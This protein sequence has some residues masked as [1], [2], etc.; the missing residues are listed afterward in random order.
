[1]MSKCSILAFWFLFFSELYENVNI[2]LVMKINFSD[3]VLHSDS[4]ITGELTWIYIVL[5]SL[6]LKYFKS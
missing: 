2:S 6:Q 3:G 1:M 4:C 5:I